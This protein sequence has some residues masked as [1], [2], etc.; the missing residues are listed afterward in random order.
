MDRT[1]TATAQDFRGD[2]RPIYLISLLL[3]AA[4]YGNAE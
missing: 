3:S 1:I 2:M 4:E